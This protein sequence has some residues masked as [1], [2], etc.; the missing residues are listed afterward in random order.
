M[1]KFLY[2]TD[3]HAKGKSPSTRTDDYPTTIVAKITHFFQ[4]GHELGVDAFLCG[5]D[6]FDSPYT[7]AEFVT[8]IGKTIQREL[9]G[10]TLY[11]V[12]GNHDVI[13]WN[14]QT[15]KRTPIGVFQEFSPFFTILERKPLT[16]VAKNGEKVNLSG[17]SS[18]A[19]LD[20]HLTDE[21]GNILHHRSRDYVIEE[22]DGT[23]QIHIVHGYLSPKPILEDIPHT[24]IDE[25]KHTKAT[26]TLMAHEHTG[27]PVT[28]ID[29]GLVYN[30]G[31]LGR[32]FASHAEMNRMP[33]YALVTIFEDGTP[34][35]QPI[36][37]PIAKIGTECMDRSLLDAKK[38]K[39]AILKEA[40]GNIRELLKGMSFEGIDLNQI[41][42]KYK[43]STPPDVYEE[44]QRRLKL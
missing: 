25:M 34:E 41:L 5:G 13:G 12:W 37:C 44:A 43:E 7:S 2:S 26:V 14:P 21:E 36:Q 8:H 9:K 16:F 3:W 11:G 32:V 39:E 38:E 29:N 20:R 15:V 17:I 24:V 18:Y 6:Y 35:I 31:A 28:K 10:K 42:M 33:K 4:L 40:K 19:Q 22:T 1:I 27:F 30:P 23:P